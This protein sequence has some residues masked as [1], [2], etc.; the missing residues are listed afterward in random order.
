MIDVSHKTLPLPTQCLPINHRI[1]FISSHS[2][3]ELIAY[4]ISSHSFSAFSPLCHLFIFHMFLSFTLILSQPSYI[5]DHNCIYLYDGTKLI[6][7][8]FHLGI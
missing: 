7:Q 4:F 5:K 3:L 6:H 8:L 2:F 1:C